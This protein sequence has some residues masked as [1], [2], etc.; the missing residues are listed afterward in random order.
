MNHTLTRDQID[1]MDDMCHAKAAVELADLEDGLG[2]VTEHGLQRS[3]ALRHR[4]LAKPGLSPAYRAKLEE[5]NYFDEQ[6]MALLEDTPDVVDDWRGI[7]V[8]VLIAAAA[9][10]AS[11]LVPQ[12]W[13]GG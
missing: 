1:G 5:E 8:G 11:M 13:F 6:A 7:V 4:I 2:V 3:I 12:R 10:I 9:C